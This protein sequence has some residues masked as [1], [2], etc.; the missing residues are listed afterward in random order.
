MQELKG[1]P[2]NL[3]VMHCTDSLWGDVEEVRRWHELR[4]FRT[5]GY[6]W[7]ITNEFPHYNNL[8]ENAPDPLYDGLVHVGRPE[9]E[10]GAH[11]KGHNEKSIGVCLV[12]IHKFTKAQHNAL[13]G[14]VVGLMN[15]Y[16]LPIERILGHCELDNKKTC[17]NFDVEALREEIRN[18]RQIEKQEILDN[19]NSCGWCGW[20]SPWRGN[21][22]IAGDK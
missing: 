6:H 9:F 3:V 4:G 16:A 11:V 19:D 18:G 5:I 12:G 13:R 15:K 20:S 8:K 17:P 7:L 21:F 14:L 1:R 22:D 10:V 2:I